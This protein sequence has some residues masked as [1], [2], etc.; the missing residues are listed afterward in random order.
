[1]IGQSVVGAKATKKGSNW[2]VET[3][4]VVLSDYNRDSQ[5]LLQKQQ[6]LTELQQQQ[7]NLK[8]LM[9]SGMTEIDKLIDESFDYSHKF[10]KIIYS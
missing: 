5:Q 3:P 8:D 4:K 10:M 1:M 7:E 6:Q 2:F 9:K